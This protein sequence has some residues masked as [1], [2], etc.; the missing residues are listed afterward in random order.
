MVGQ[1]GKAAAGMA[2]ILTNWEIVHTDV[3]TLA[4]F[5]A[6]SLSIWQAG[7]EHGR[8]QVIK[9][10]QKTAEATHILSNSAMGEQLKQSLQFAIANSVTAHRLAVLTKEAGDEAA[11]LAS[12]V[13]VKQQAAL[14]QEHLISQAKVDALAGTRH[15]L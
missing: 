14:L 6:I 2:I 3:N 13:V 12:D 7:K 1:V 5:V 10:V 15:S 9:S 4:I 8:D 11:A